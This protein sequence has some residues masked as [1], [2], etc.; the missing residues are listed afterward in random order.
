MSSTKKTVVKSAKN[1]R[2][3]AALAAWETRRENA[4]KRSD[5]A[6]RAWKTRK[7]NAK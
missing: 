3:D 2:R 5:A 6:K 4:R 7:R 1:V